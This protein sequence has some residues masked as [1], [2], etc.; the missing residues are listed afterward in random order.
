MLIKCSSVLILSYRFIKKKKKM[1]DKNSNPL[2]PYNAS[3]MSPVLSSQVVDLPKKN[4][5]WQFKPIK[6]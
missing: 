5:M 2:Y 4:E 6:N 1:K 3:R